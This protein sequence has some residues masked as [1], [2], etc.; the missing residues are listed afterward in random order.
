MTA[1]LRDSASH[2]ARYLLA[3]ALAPRLPVVR[4]SGR[5]ADGHPG[6]IVAAGHG[7]V[8]TTLAGLV[9][10]VAET[11]ESLGSVAVAGLRR[12]LPRLAGEADLVVA[13]VP[14]LMGDLLRGPA[15]VMPEAVGMRAT[16]AEIQRRRR[17]SSSVRSAERRIQLAGL[18]ARQS[19]DPAELDL[20][21][22]TMYAPFARARFGPSAV[23][24]GREALRRRLRQGALF[25]VE[26]AG[27]RV[28]GFL[29][30]QE[31]PVVHLL[32]LGTCLDPAAARACGV[33]NGV[34]LFAA[35][36]ALARGAAFLD[37]GGSL[38]WLGDG[39]LRS[40]HLWGAALAPKRWANGALLVRW[41]AWSPA[42]A[43][44]VSLGPIVEGRARRPEALALVPAASE[45]TPEAAAALTRRL[46]VDG[47]T[48]LSVLAEHGWS[49]AG[50]MPPTTP[51][52][53]LLPAGPSAAAHPDAG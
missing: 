38:P 16:V 41:D 9:L 31:G 8:L 19:T 39:S 46:A 36:H 11:R 50:P 3:P 1:R 5:T 18:A 29:V 6:S 25:W 37:L 17:V 34:R 20:F 15:L 27:E 30:E 32:I 51:P 49:D 23:V 52:V 48:R 26:R 28:A 4:I 10:P 21:H 12:A 42:A 40:K 53:H 13:R 47:L 43:A 45:A 14:R 22:E 24:R 7:S 33:L 44:F 2:A 35:D